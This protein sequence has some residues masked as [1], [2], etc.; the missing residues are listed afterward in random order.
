[1]TIY[2]N[3]NINPVFIWNTKSRKAVLYVIVCMC[4]CGCVCLCMCVCVCMRV[5]VCVDGKA[6]EGNL[7]NKARM[8][9]FIK[10][11][12]DVRVFLIKFK[13]AKHSDLV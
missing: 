12:K 10:L 6:K 3:N 9:I 8:T 11:N 5:C 7:F 13:N 2:Y 4:L 1:M